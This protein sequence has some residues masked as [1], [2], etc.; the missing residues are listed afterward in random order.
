MNAA[1]AKQMGEQAK[2]EAKERWSLA[3][4]GKYDHLWMRVHRDHETLAPVQTDYI[5]AWEDPDTGDLRVTVPSPN[6]MASLL[7][8]GTAPPVEDLLE[9]KC[10]WWNDE[11]D[12]G[13][14][15]DNKTNP[16]E[17][18]QGGVVL[19]GEVQHERTIGPLTE[20]EAI[21][22]ILMKD[23]PNAVWEDYDRSNR[24]KFAIIK[25]K[26]LPSN[27]KFRNVWELNQ[28]AA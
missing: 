6:F 17:G 5:I 24:R 18:W 7:N 26:Q 8:G 10:V 25:R 20:E 4:E 16:G 15:T 27:R 3:C 2:A 14:I 28:E 23:V 13:L 19:N 12:A 11:L 9:L 1:Q 21:E 22:Y